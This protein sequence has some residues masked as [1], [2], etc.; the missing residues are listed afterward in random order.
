MNRV[1]LL[2]LES[3]DRNFKKSAFE[4]ATIGMKLAADCRGELHA[5]IMGCGLESKLDEL[6]CFGISKIY[7]I[8]SAELECFHVHTYAPALFT[9]IKEI[10]P[11]IVLGISS[12]IGKD[13]FPRLSAMLGVTM[14]SDCIN[15]ECDN[16][17]IIATRPVYSGKIFVK[18]RFT[19]GAPYIAT[20]RVNSAEINKIESSG[21]EVKKIQFIKIEKQQGV[22]LEIKEGEKKKIGITQADIVISGGRALKNS[23]DFSILYEIAD[24]V[25]GAVAASRASVDAGCASYDMQVGQTGKTVSPKLYMCFGISGAVQHIAG[26]N[27]SKLIVAVNKDP[28][29]PIFKYADYGIIGDVYEIAQEIKKMLNSGLL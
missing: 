11:Y 25:G 26:A 10:Q 28:D 19:K 5:V 4:L 17:S 8:E 2:F 24:I 21:F 6:K 12:I 16:N 9:L 7:Y 14:V 27:G 3:G 18:T 13:L 20:L 1:T 23:N 22:L 15:I 29:A